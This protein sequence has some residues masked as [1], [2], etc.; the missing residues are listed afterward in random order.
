MLTS[1]VKPEELD[2]AIEELKRNTGY[3]ERLRELEAQ[4]RI[5]NGVANKVA[6]VRIIDNG[7]GTSFID[8]RTTNPRSRSELTLVAQGMAKLF[9]APLTRQVAAE[10]HDSGAIPFRQPPKHSYW[11]A[12]KV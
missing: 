7:N 2:G 5:V 1:G 3:Y 12:S 4:D 11:K 6:G 10:A 8:V 9:E